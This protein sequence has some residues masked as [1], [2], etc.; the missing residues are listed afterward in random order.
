MRDG[1]FPPDY[2]IDRSPFWVRLLD[3]RIRK[4]D[5]RSFIIFFCLG[6]VCMLVSWWLIENTTLMQHIYTLYDKWFIS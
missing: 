6:V 1:Y 2:N 3:P 5:R 4:D